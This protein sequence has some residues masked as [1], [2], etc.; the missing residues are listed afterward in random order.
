MKKL[1]FLKDCTI[2]G[3]LLTLFKIQFNH[4]VKNEVNILA[5]LV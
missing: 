5:V 3:K 2:L 4:E 1:C